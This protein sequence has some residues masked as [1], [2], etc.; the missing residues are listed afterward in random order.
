MQMMS[1]KALYES[2]NPT[3][4]FGACCCIKNPRA[5]IECCYMRFFFTSES[6]IITAK[7]GHLARSKFLKRVTVAGVE[8]YGRDD[9]LRKFIAQ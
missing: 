7:K 6:K 8:L 9:N 1:A 3:S 5:N 2:S 4:L